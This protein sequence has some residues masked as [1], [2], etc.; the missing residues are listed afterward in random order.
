MFQEALKRLRE[1][2][3]TVRKIIKTNENLRNILGQENFEDALPLF[4]KIKQ[5]IPS[6]KEWEIYEH[7]AT[8]TRLYAIYENFIE[9]LIRNW[10]V[11]LPQIYLNYTELD[12][13]IKITYQIGVGK[14]LIDLNKNRYKSLSIEDVVGGIFRGVSHDSEYELLPDAF[15]IYEQNLRKEILD[16]LLADAGIPNA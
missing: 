15:L 1:R 8:V 9:E 5:D 14:L 12:E 4:A 10:L 2:I 13:R 3:S 11:I 6:D 16:R 7:C